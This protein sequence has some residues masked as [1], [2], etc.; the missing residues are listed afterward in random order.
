MLTTLAYEIL[1][2][3]LLGGPSWMASERYDVAAKAEQPEGT[4]LDPTSM[5][6][7]QIQSQIFERLRVLLADRFHLAVHREMREAPVYILV[8]GKRRSMLQ[9]SHVSIEQ[10]ELRSRRGVVSAQGVPLEMLTKLLSKE[11]GRSVID[12]TGLG[13]LFDFKLEWTP[14]V[15][16]G[17][18]KE[19]GLPATLVPAGPSLFTAIQEQLGLRLKSGRSPIKVILVDRLERPSPN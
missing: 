4:T 8:V 12:E 9:P 7:D 1:D 6:D 11:L 17:P 14:D 16:G 2:F 18:S 3:Q 19:D 10:R 13:G 5:T 15:T